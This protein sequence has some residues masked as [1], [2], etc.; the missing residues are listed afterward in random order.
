[1]EHKKRRIFYVDGDYLEVL[2]YYDEEAGQ[3]FGE[4]PNF[5]EEPRYTPSGRKWVNVTTVGCPH[6]DIDY[7]DC[8]SCQ[9]MRREQAMDL[10]GVCYN[11]VYQKK[12]KVYKMEA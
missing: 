12:E 7:D 2:F 10:I 6:A 5:E 4:Y 9:H 3:H 1:M 8:G 11:S